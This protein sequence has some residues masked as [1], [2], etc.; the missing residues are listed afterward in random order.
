MKESVYWILVVTIL[1]VSIV[2]SINNV[3]QMNQIADLRARV[4]VLE[5]AMEFASPEPAL[6]RDPL[7]PRVR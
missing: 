3:I 1:A 4:Q 7:K 6:P 5:R 2:Q